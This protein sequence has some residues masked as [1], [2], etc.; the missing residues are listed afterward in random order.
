MSLEVK[1]EE[2]M[3]YVQFHISECLLFATSSGNSKYSCTRVNNQ[4]QHGSRFLCGF[5]RSSQLNFR[6]QKTSRIKFSEK[7]FSEMMLDAYRPVLP[8]TH[9]SSIASE[10][11]LCLN[12]SLSSVFSC[13]RLRCN[14][15]IRSICLLSFEKIKNRI[16]CIC[17]QLHVHFPIAHHN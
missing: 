13:L 11:L 16:K 9:L 17:L 8:V 1:V 14:Y 12:I 3:T 7:K 15:S 2:N 5:N 4:T 6:I 10:S